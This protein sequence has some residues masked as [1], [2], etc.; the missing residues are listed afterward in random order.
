MSTPDDEKDF[1]LTYL[2]SYQP[3]VAAFSGTGTISALADAV[4]ILKAGACQD[5]SLLGTFTENH[6]VP[7]FAQLTGDFALAKNALAFTM[8]T[9]G[10][11]VIYQGQEQHYNSEGG[12]SYP[13]NREALWFSGYDTT[14]EL[15]T[16]ITS[17]NAIRKNAIADDAEYL[18]Y[19]N[20]PVYT[21]DTTIAMRKG[22]MLTVLS[23][24]GESGGSSTVSVTGTGFE[25]GVQ[26]TELLS[27]ETLTS[28][29]GTLDVPFEAGLPRVYYPTVG[30]SGSGICAGNS[31]SRRLRTRSSRL[32]RSK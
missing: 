4:S 10:I 1:Q 28:S 29:A 15:Y 3:L 11:P 5:T 23:T 19:Q 16:F 30:I 22:S 12:V 21:D 32:W 7:R 24:L 2:H 14:A 8:L 6:D 25:D 13:Y 20:N 27:C 31:T 18:T 17:L 9:D 26:L